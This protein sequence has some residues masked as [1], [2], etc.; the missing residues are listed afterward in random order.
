MAE[1]VTRDEAL[2]ERISG[3][4]VPQPAPLGLA[5]AAV[6]LLKQ[7]RTLPAKAEAA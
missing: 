3:Y 5:I 6:L 4:D 7:F 2:A 1:V